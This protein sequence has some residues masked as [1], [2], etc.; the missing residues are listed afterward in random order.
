M[1][2]REAIAAAIRT[3]ILNSLVG[4]VVAD[5]AAGLSPADEAIVD[6]YLDTLM[7]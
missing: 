1:T 3:Y 5:L 2:W 4:T 6:A 7:P